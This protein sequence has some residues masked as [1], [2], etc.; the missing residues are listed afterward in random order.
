MDIKE[1]IKEL[2]ELKDL[3]NQAK[4]NQRQVYG[5][6][7]ASLCVKHMDAIIEHIEGY[8]KRSSGP[9]VKKAFPQGR[10]VSEGGKEIKDPDKE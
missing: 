9:T 1:V 6:E 10:L 2:K 7:Y 8:G 5:K 3:Y 4:T